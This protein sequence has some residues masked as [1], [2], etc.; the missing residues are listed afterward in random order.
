MWFFPKLLPKFGDTQL[1]RMSA[2]A[3]FPFSG[4]EVPK[5]V[6]KASSIK[7]LF[8]KVGVKELKISDLNPTEDLRDELEY[9]LHPMANHLTPVSELTNTPG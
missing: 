6:H 9:Q 1:Y 2:L 4:T 7:S 5:R 3:L 8:A